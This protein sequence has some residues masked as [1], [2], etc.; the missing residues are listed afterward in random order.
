MDGIHLKDSRLK[1]SGVEIIK[2]EPFIIENESEADEYLRDLFDKHEYRSIDEVNML[3]QKYIR[4][5][6]FE[7]TSSIRQK[8]C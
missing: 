3:A 4:D 8:K 5:A 2:I 7:S 1:V 6:R